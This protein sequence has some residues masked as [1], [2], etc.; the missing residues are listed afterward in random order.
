MYTTA[1]QIAGALG[2]AL[3]GF[4]D[5]S[6]LA[7]SSNPLYAFIISV[8]VITLLSAGLSLSVLPL[9]TARPPI[10]GNEAHRQEPVQEQKAATEQVQQSKEGACLTCQNV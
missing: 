3:I 4:L 9:A 10:T 6:L 8:L 7:S 1:S 5:A 2:V